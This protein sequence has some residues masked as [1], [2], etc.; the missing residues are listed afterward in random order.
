L[1]DRLTESHTLSTDSPHVLAYL[2]GDL[3]GL[4]FGIGLFFQGER[5]GN[6]TNTFTLPSFL[7]TD[8]TVFY[9]RDCFRASI[10]LQN[11]FDVEYYEGSR[12]NTDVRVVVGAPFTISGQIAWEF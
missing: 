4:G 8:A 5:Q 1:R 3:E 7:R 12:D 6:L 10:N 2:E 9:R 11:L